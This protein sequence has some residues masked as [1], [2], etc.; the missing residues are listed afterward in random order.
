[1]SNLKRVILI[2]AVLTLLVAAIPVLVM[3]NSSLDPDTEFYV[4][5]RNQ[6]AI[7]QIADLT[8]NG[9][10]ATAD[11]VRA[12]IETPQSVWFESGSPK[13]V[14]QAVKNTVK[15]AAGKG[16]VPVLVAYNL[17]FRDCAQFSAGGATTVDEYTAWIDGFAKGIGKEEAVVILEPDGLG[18]IPWYTNIDGNLDWC[19]PS[20]ADP[21][22]AAAERFFMM[23][24][25]VDTI[26]AQPNTHVYLDGTHSGWLNVGDA[27][28]RLA[29]AGVDR[30]DGFYLNA[31]NY[32]FTA[33]LVKYGTW[34][35]SCLAMGNFAGCPNQYW[36]GG[37]PTGWNGTAMDNY[38][39]WRN[40]PYSGDPADLAWNTVGIDSRYAGAQ[41]TTHFVIDSSRN[42]V[43]PWAPPAYPDAQD[44]CNPPDRGLGFAPT[45]DT[46]IPLL[47]AYLW[48][49][50]PGE[51]DGECT[52]GLGPAGETIDPVWDLI[53]P[54]AGE[55]FPE[56]VLDLVQ[57]ANPALD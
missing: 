20:E 30:A 24:Y 16:T 49:K 40:E 28:Q 13:K 15:R 51:S 43:G 29:R 45:A 11:L 14:Q 3:A 44:W 39:E 9:D 41:P 31:S 57:N 23:N 10:K 50:I 36:N 22:T 48:I 12:M 54:P 53:D 37:P 38:Q 18:I 35:S 7:R 26:K 42:G 27:S 5:K 17:P 6:G 55:W 46:G 21:D 4:A 47:D 52:R 1:M 25:A 8:S 32:Q 33:N 19:Q 2:T 56:M 34:V